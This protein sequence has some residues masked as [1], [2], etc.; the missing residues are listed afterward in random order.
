VED[1]AAVTKANFLCNEMGMDTIT[2]GA[3]IACAMEMSERGIIPAKE[4]GLGRELKFGDGL[5]VV[6]LTRMTGRMEGFG[7]LLAE[8]S[9]RLAQ[10]FGHPE[11]AMVSKGQEFAGYDPR[12]EQGMGLA[13]ATSPIG[14]S[15]MRGDPAYIELLGV[16]K[17]IDPLTYRDKPQIVKDWQDAFA[18][19]DA[20]GLC[21]FFSVRNYV[22][23][24]E[25]IKPE[26][27]AE[28]LS[29]ATGLDYTLDEVCRAGERIFNAER[30]FLTRAG[31]SRKDDSL[32]KRIVSEPMPD[33][34]AKG[35]VCHLEEML[36]KYYR[37]R[38]WD[39]NGIPEQAKL[40]E[41]G[42]A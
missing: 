34:P 42:L 26:G 31:F 14:A 27:I 1:L 36:D 32:P 28:L 19:I 20:A 38:G 5:A 4:I 16:P 37:L 6:E 9:L 15:H 8:G 25:T 21:V 33:G 13:Y 2:M 3:T 11:F 7:R 23:P 39:A 18:V 40:K 41:L 30:L 22:R 24:D 17:Q 12:G 29:A 35:M 10:H